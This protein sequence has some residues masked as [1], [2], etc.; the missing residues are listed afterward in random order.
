MRSNPILTLLDK[1]RAAVMAVNG[2]DS[3]VS[4]DWYGV[5][6]LVPTWNYVAVHLRGQLCRLPQADLR[7][8]LERLSLAM[9]TRL[10]PKSIWGLEKLTDENFAKMARMIVPVAMQVDQVDGTWKLGQNKPP[11]SLAGA[12]AGVSEYGF[13]VETNKLAALMQDPPGSGGSHE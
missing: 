5:G 4:P 8:V 10:L 6:Q 3:Y 11:A 12:A 9:E 7:G 1:P 2:G 13:G